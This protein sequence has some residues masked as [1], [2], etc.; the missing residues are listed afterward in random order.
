MNQPDDNLIPEPPPEVFTAPKNIPCYV[1]VRWDEITNCYVAETHWL[2][3]DVTISIL[4]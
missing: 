3:G 1:E 2:N 4:P